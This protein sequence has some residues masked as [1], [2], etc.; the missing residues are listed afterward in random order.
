MTLESQAG[1]RGDDSFF[2]SPHHGH[3]PHPKMIVFSV[4]GTVEI[5]KGQRIM[6]E[7]R[8][9]VEMATEKLDFRQISKLTL[10]SGLK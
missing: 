7:R 4:S 3:V 5:P 6:N 1:A 10:F 2:K 9:V 8:I